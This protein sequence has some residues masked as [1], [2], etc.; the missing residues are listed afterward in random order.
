MWDFKPGQ[1]ETRPKRM[2]G[3]LKMVID[4][5]LNTTAPSATIA[6]LL[7]HT[8]CVDNESLNAPL[9]A[10]RAH[11]ARELFKEVGAREE[12][13][14][15]AEPATQGPLPSDKL[16]ERAR[17]RSVVILVIPP[18]KPTPSP[19]PK[20]K[21][22][23]PSGCTPAVGILPTDRSAYDANKSWLPFAYVNNATCACNQTPNSTTANCVRRFLQDRLAATP[24]NI[25]DFG[26]KNKVSR[27]CQSAYLRGLVQG[28]L[29]PNIFQDHKDAYKSC[30][31]PSTPAAFPAWVGVTT[32][33][34]VPCKTVGAFIDIFG[35]CH[36]TPGKR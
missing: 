18:P 8:D 19:G 24:K 30:C 23:A 10:G 6:I 35:S 5:S 16:E 3:T 28:T 9:R 2:A 14:G 25:K 33:P 13:L 11:A 12:F 34:I 20:P 7:G 32:V 1:A 22:D 26:E 27:D 29:T 4:L 15:P 31:C 17:N 21:E 36:G